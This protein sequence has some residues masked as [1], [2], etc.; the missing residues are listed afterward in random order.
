MFVEN[1]TLN[2]ENQGLVR[3][4]C[5]KCQNLCH[6]NGETI[7]LHLLKDGM[8]MSYT[9]WIW[10]GEQLGK[11]GID[12]E[13]TNTYSM[14]R[15]VDDHYRDNCPMNF[16]EDAEIQLYPA[17]VLYKHKTMYRYSNKSFDNLL[18]I[19]CDMLPE[20]NTILNSTRSVEML[21]KPFQLDCIRIHACVNDF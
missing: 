8:D 17:A 7:V 5:K 16:V 21:L 12:V 18:E 15:D 9:T 3:C 6:Q 20:L 19:L 10:H 13:M 11:K 14:S 1:A 4:P 2:V